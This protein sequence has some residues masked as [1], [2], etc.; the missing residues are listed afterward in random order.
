MIINKEHKLHFKATTIQTEYENNSNNNK[1]NNN[2]KQQYI[3]NA[4]K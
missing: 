4:K 3:G 2:T 1:Y